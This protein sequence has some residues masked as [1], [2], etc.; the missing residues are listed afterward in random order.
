MEFYKF[1]AP[2]RN[3]AV[4]STA[5]TVNGI[6]VYCDVVKSAD[7]QYNNITLKK[8]NDPAANGKF[9]SVLGMD[10]ELFAT[11]SAAFRPFTGK[12]VSSFKTDQP[13]VI[14]QLPQTCTVSWGNLGV[15][16]SQKNGR[17]CQP[18]AAQNIAKFKSL[19]EQALVGNGDG[20]PNPMF[21]GQVV[22]DLNGLQ[23]PMLTKGTLVYDAEGTYL[24]YDIACNL[25]SESVV[26]STGETK[27]VNYGFVPEEAKEII[28]P[29]VEQ[30][31]AQII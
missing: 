6:T 25:A 10:K 27:Y 3:G 26:A 19:I 5:C 15:P 8:R 30:F 23:L 17:V 1:N 14:G 4:G 16:G 18:K 20:N 12:M 11:M 7:G 22:V 29:A 21:L 24:G 9:Y 13:L 2:M 28:A 31:V